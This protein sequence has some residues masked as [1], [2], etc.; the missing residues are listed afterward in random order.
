M[1]QN[2][3]WITVIVIK[4]TS[5]KSEKISKT[6]F[7]STAF[8]LI[9]ALSIKI[10]ILNSFK[11]RQINVYAE[12]NRIIKSK[13]EI[14][15]S[16]IQKLFVSNNYIFRSIHKRNLIIESYLTE[17]NAIIFDIWDSIFMTNLKKTSVKIHKK[18]LFERLNSYRSLN[19][20]S[21]TFTNFHHA[22]VFFEK[23]INKAKF[24][25]DET[26]FEKI[27]S[28]TDFSESINSFLIESIDSNDV[29][30]LDV[31]DH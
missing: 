4:N 6:I 26:L 14:N 16:I 18:Q 5:A 30:K 8:L 27:I 12:K 28:E 10:K 2:K 20:I 13:H 17:I 21:Q 25:S 9:I 24:D 11:R 31:S 22:D 29:L 7:F 19:S 15:V 3:H 23:K 1:I